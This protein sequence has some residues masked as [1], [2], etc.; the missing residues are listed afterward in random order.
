MGANEVMHPR[1]VD[2]AYQISH[3]YLTPAGGCDEDDR[4]K[5]ARQVLSIYRDQLDN[6]VVDQ[7]VWMSYAPNIVMLSPYCLV[8]Q[9]TWMPKVPLI[10]LDIVEE[11]LIDH[12][13]RRDDWS[14]ADDEFLGGD[15]DFELGYYAR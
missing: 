1:R 7:F 6:M 9:V 13:P 8:S 10:C 3:N 15:A 12:A 14:R 11:Q 4:F 5:K 2:D